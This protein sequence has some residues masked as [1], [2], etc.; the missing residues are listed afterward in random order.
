LAQRN[1][2]VKFVKE[3]F[4]LVAGTRLA[5]NIFVERLKVQEGGGWLLKNVI[6]V[7]NTVNVLNSQI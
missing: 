3:S 7:A 4:F 6:D 5:R 1:I 2:L